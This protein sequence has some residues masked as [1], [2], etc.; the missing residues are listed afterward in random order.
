MIEMD[1][2]CVWVVEPRNVVGLLVDVVD[3]ELQVK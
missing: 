3:Q 2:S 1:L